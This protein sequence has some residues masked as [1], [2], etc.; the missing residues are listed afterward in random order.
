MKDKGQSCARSTGEINYFLRFILLNLVDASHYDVKKRNFAQA[1]KLGV[2][3]DRKNKMW[4]LH[5]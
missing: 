2:M 3:H 5:G 4:T 1:K